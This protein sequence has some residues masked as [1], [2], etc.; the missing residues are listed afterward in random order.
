MVFEALA[1][2]SSVL[3]AS[4]AI[5]QGKEANAQKRAEAAQIDQER[6]AESNSY[7]SYDSN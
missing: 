5:A 1:I 6:R 2:A 4:A 3:S 7:S